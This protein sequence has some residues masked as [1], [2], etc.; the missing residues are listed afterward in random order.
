MGGVDLSD[1]VIYFYAF[2][3]KSNH[4]QNSC[5]QLTYTSFNK[6]LY[7]IPYELTVGLLKNQVRVHKRCD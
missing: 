1:Q 6:F 7:N 2:E 3:Q 4:I 5:I